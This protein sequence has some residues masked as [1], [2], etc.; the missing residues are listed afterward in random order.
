MFDTSILRHYIEFRY[1]QL[2]QHASRVNRTMPAIISGVSAIDF[3]QQISS[4]IYVPQ[5][6]KMARPLFL[7]AH[8]HASYLSI[9]Q[10][11]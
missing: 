9:A 6:E 10:H 1:D 11:A 4:R 3:R 8:Y 2:F 7:R 5:R